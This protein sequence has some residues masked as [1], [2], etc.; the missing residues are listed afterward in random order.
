MA[1]T[2]SPSAARLRAPRWFDGRIAVGL[3]LVVVSV[4][5]GAQVVGR[6][7]DATEVWALRR[8]LPTGT[9]LTDDD[10]TRTRVRLYGADAGRYLDGTGRSPSGEVLARDVGVGELLPVAAL[11]DSEGRQPRRLVTVPVAKSHA[12]GGA[13]HR[14]DRID[15]VATFGT[16]GQRTVTRPVLRG[17]LVVEVIDESGSFGAG[18]ADFA[19]VV[20]VSPDQVLALTSALQSA[21]L[22]LV[23]V[24]PGMGG[25]G[26][27]GSGSVT[28]GPTR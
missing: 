24:L 8:A 28:T 27:I 1:E 15:I 21:Q 19:V 17:V 2:R 26:D 12:L 5:V 3:L 22:D 16:R 18:S 6:A 20:S 13:L 11:V 14:G 25:L 7:D 10:L 23:K 4:V 9:V